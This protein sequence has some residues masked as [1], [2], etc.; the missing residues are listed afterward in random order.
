MPMVAV[1]KAEIFATRQQRGIGSC[2]K[3]TIIQ[4]ERE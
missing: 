1:S 4:L 2:G 3:C